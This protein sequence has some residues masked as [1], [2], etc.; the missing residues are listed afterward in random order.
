[1]TAQVLRLPAYEKAK[2]ISV[3]LSMP[4]REVST[5][6]VVRDAFR[7]GKAVFVPHIHRDEAGGSRGSVMDMLRLKDEDDLDSLMPDAWGIPTLS[8]DSIAYR[9]NALGGHGLQSDNLEGQL[10]L[11]FVPAVA[12]DYS[13][14]RLGHGKGFYDRYLTRYSSIAAQNGSQ[15]PDLG[16]FRSL[17]AVPETD[18]YR[19]V[20]L[21]LSVQ[22]LPES[23][24]VPVDEN[25]WLVDRVIVPE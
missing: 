13:R 23:E 1:M 18:N 10:D 19:T 3:F 12:F 5:I 20:G 25:D 21:G 24:S 17:H 14:R 16:G 15:M 2:G 8:S 7:S 4:E 11:I 6:Q 9:Q 22:I